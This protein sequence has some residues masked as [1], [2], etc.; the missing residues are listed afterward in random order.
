MAVAFFVGAAVATC[1]PAVG[2]WPGQSS[3]DA[4]QPPEDVFGHHQ[5][6][7]NV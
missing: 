2:T 5:I 4:G 3:K 7:L 1:V 6:L